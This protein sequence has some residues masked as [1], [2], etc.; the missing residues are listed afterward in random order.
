MHTIKLLAIATVIVLAPIVTAAEVVVSHFEPLQRT[1]ISK[2]DKSA[3]SFS[4]KPATPASVSI[5][6]D[7]LGKNFDLQL[8]SNDRVASG[9]PAGAAK[10]EV[11]I[12][13]G[14]L[15]NNPQS[16]ARIVVFDGMPR[17]MIWDGSEMYA[18][19][20]PDDS[21]LPIDAPV[22]YRL[23]DA[24]VVS[25]TMSCGSDFLSGSAATIMKE[26]STS[27]KTAIARAPGAVTQM[28]MSAIGDFE[29]TNARGGDNAAVAAIT[30]RLNNVDGF[31]SEQV[32]V[33]INVDLIETHSDQADPF[34]DTLIA[35]DLLDEV[36]EYR[37]QSPDHNS[38]GLTHLYTGR[39]LDTTTVG[40]A[41]R[42]VL[43]EDY[44]GAGLSEGN[45]G[46]TNDS[47]IAAHEIGHNFGAEHDGEPLTPCEADTGA[48]IMSA[49]INGSQQ[50]SAC[51]ISIMQAEAAAASCAAALPAVDVSVQ[52]LSQLSSVLLGAQTDLVYE[53]ASNGTLD[54]AGVRVNFSVPNVLSLQSVATSAGTC[55]NGAGSVDCNLGNLAGLSS[56]S[57][58][59]S[60][61][62]NALG[63][64]TLTANVTT[65]DT[66][67]RPIN[68]QNSVL[69]TVEP[70]VD[71]IAGVP[72]S[73]AVFIDASTSVS[74][75]LNNASQINATNATASVTLE[76]GLQP[77]S[78][79]W[80]IGTCT[81]TAQR[82]D[83]LA[84]TFA[85]QTN[86]LLT[87]NARG[88]SSGRRDV[89]VV[90]SSTEADTNPDDNSSLGEVRVVAPDDAKDDGGGSTSPVAILLALCALLSA[91]RRQVQY[92]DK[93]L[94]ADLEN[95]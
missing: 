75:T 26:I 33:Q 5:R 63:T 50:F 71:L 20:A 90:L 42:G 30:T 46:A 68:N 73:A 4:S 1:L 3:H 93:Q 48:F 59:L 2:T 47:L 85:A 9:L 45:A 29:F 23:A 78:A 35:A 56:A 51:S 19:E 24:F 57:I 39:N 28:T 13:R 79:T 65:T 7:A 76:N 25:G 81:V 70:A 60:V 11:E 41:W 40:I 38:R 95:A 88:I 10:S 52:P 49:S 27:S 53:V 15:A 64:G 34:G 67:E 54:A 69:L 92:A 32:G 87:I 66:D 14:Q 17:G 82:V 18:I 91:R 72:T 94:M 31:F 22:I 37:L 21:S 74:V 83:C 55:S 84:G 77:V 58:T 89:T 12:Y 8:V 43:C 86:S 62:A 36:S 80:S 44:F 16:W 61:M 6:F